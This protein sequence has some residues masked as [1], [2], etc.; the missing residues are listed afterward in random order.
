M[1]AGL[2]VDPLRPLP[3][4]VRAHIAPRADL[5]RSQ[6]RGR[7]LDLADLPAVD[8]APLEALA[9]SESDTGGYD[10]IVSIAQ[11]VHL[12]DLPAALEALGR[13]LRPGGELWLVEP[14]GRPGMAAAVQAWAWSAHPRLAGL[15]LSRDVPAALRATGMT[16]TDIERF[17]VLT[18]LWPLRPF[19]QLRATWVE[20]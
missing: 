16:I 20:A 2:L 7:V 3:R 6:A 1:P 5:V 14:I 10:T 13:L 4:D 8:D 12:A 18:D 9:L 19:V 15:Q 17:T 11:L